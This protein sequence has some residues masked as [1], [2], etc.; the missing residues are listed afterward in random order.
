VCAVTADQC[1]GGSGGGG[2]GGGGSGGDSW[3]CRQSWYDYPTTT[4]NAYTYDEATALTNQ[5]CQSGCMRCG[6]QSCGVQSGSGPYT[7][8]CHYY[9]YNEGTTYETSLTS[10]EASALATAECRSA[11]HQSCG[12]TCTKN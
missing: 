3:T 6:T 9:C 11:N 2:S 5:E 7:F 8:L 10:A 12:A 1:D 4:Q